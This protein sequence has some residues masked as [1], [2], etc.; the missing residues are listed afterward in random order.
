MSPGELPTRKITIEEADLAILRSDVWSMGFVPVKLEMEGQ[1][2][3]A[4]LGYR[5]G[6]TR[7]YPKK[8]YEVVYGNNQTL[9]WNAEFDDPSMLRNMFSFH[10]FNMIGVPSPHTRHFLL[11]WNGQP[12][13]VYLEL[14]AVNQ[15]F[16]Q[17][18]GIRSRALI[19]A[20]NDHANFSELDPDTKMKKLWLLSGYH[21]MKGNKMTPVR[22]KRFLKGINRP[23][24]NKLRTFIGKRLDI[25]NYLK[26]L[27]GAVLTGN[28]DGF[29]QNYALYEHVPSGKYRIIPWDYEG[30]WGR[31]CYGKLCGSDLVSV[32]GY[33]VLTRK[34]LSY[35]SCREDYRRILTR[36][37]ADQFTMK[38]LDPILI[39]M[40]ER[41]L[42]A[43]RDDFTRKSPF[44][45]FLEEPEVFRTYIKER[46]LIVKDV[47]RSWKA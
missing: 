42:P 4:R 25:R 8:S 28:Y 21:V 11:E 13:G 34:V 36:L 23:A 30:T 19:Y 16:F 5:G 18:R 43:I 20:V 10:F 14:E 1:I 24:D 35:R 40:H 32:K 44:A 31:N 12:H 17:T 3:D 29:D 47:L 26:W 33:N 37:L 38:R 9:H 7:N 39:Q 27:A 22:L 6:H 15:T 46:R 2:Y 41:L 45:T